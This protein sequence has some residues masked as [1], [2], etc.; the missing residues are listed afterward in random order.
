MNV[1]TVNIVMNN[2]GTG[3]IVE[4]VYR[5]STDY[6]HGI[7]QVIREV[8]EVMAA[9]RAEQRTQMV[10]FQAIKG[11]WHGWR[12]TIGMLPPT[13]I[14][15]EVPKGVRKQFVLRCIELGSSLALRRKESLP[16]GSLKV[17]I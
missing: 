14:F 16:P 11:L 5:E 2:M 13:A 12:T 4:I 7:L 17:G 1:E 6:P 10:G 9:H 8:E 15:G 3:D